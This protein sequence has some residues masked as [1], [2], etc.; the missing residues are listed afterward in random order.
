[1]PGEINGEQFIIQNCKNSTI[2]LYDFTNTVLIDDCQECTI[3]VGPVIGRYFFGNKFN[4]PK[5]IEYLQ[6]SITKLS[7]LSS[8]VRIATISITRL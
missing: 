4:F 5:L 8:N 3:F 7:K 2:C 6:H 1:M